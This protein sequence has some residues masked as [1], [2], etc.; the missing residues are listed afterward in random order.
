MPYLSTGRAVV[1]QMIGLAFYGCPS[2]FLQYD[3]DTRRMADNRNEAQIN[4]LILELQKSCGA[5][6]VIANWM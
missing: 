6:R 4:G 2:M 3:C 1:L 5:Q